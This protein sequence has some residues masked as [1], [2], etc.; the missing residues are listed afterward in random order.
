MR[1]DR[2]NARTVMTWRSSIEKKNG[3]NSPS[4]SNESLDDGSGKV[5]G[6]QFVI[7]ELLLL[8]HAGISL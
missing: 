7:M 8:H 4:A 6:D 3:E 1:L 2:V 5:N